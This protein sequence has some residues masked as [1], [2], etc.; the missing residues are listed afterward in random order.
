MSQIETSPAPTD[1]SPAFL[2]L[3]EEA[4]Q[5]SYTSE[6]TP[7]D[8]LDAL[9]QASESALGSALRELFRARRQIGGR[10]LA[11]A[12]ETLAGVRAT[13]AEIPRWRGRLV[14]VEASLR[15]NRLEFTAALDLFRT[16]LRLHREEGT[17]SDI[18]AALVD[19]G[20]VKVTLDL[21]AEAIGDLR[22]GLEIWRSL[23]NDRCVALAMGTLGHAHCR[24]GDPASALHCAQ[25]ALAV[26]QRLGSTVAIFD[27]LMTLSE[28]LQLLGRFD[29]AIARAEEALAMTASFDA[30]VP[31]I[32]RAHNTVGTAYL[33]R[34]DY[35]RALEQFEQEVAIAA[36][37]DIRVHMACGLGNVGDVL[38]RRGDYA[39]SLEGSQR[40]LAIFEELDDLRNQAVTMSY[41]AR[42][43]DGLGRHADA[44][45]H[46]E[47]ALAIAERIGALD[48][49]AEGHK[50]LSEHLERTGS[51]DVALAHLKSFLDARE[52]MTTEE[53]RRQLDALEATRKLELAEKEREIERLRSVE[54][55]EALERLKSAQSQLVHAEKMASL[56]TVTAGI[57]HEINNATNFVRS[58][59]RPLRRD[60]EQLGLET[61]GDEERSEVLDE[62]RKLLN[63]IEEGADRTAEIVRSLRT[64]SRLD[65]D[66]LKPVD[67]HEGI[68][69]TLA[70]LQPRLAGIELVRRYG[71]LPEVECYPGEINQVFMNVLAN[72]IDACASGGTIAITTSSDGESARVTVSDTGAGIAAEDL[73]RVFEPFFTTKP[74]GKGQGLGLSIAYAIVERHGGELTVESA[75]GAGATVTMMLP[76]MRTHA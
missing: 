17:P 54:L 48:L 9:A 28:V 31:S 32:L 2:S 47:R 50:A 26:N 38:G 41:V 60:V 7:P 37:H 53:A 57:A 70:V 10:D 61:L 68:D 58:A 18:A 76:L 52:A 20:S 51:F 22:E 35:D 56:G 49:L 40:A 6:P 65:E 4:W 33:G 39:A 73:S 16:A 29:E 55:A 5:R 8:Q 64:F 75:P 15:R 74:V 42:A 63:G 66:A 67:I 21:F 34:G 25:D 69:S 46:Y 12:E 11:Q 44:R 3:F 13:L 19:G 27:C 1:A 59:V 23:G 45:T 71:E 62:V 72:A 43:L 30:T 36:E 14:T 24:I